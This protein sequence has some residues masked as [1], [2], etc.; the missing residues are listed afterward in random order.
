[1]QTALQIPV[2]AYGISYFVG[3][4]IETLSTLSSYL[5]KPAIL[6]LCLVLIFATRFQKSIGY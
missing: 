3:I 2:F 6:A 5:Q 4:G 1:L